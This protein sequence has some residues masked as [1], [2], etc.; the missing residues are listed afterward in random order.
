[1]KGELLFLAWIRNLRLW[2]ASQL[3][4]AILAPTAPSPSANASFAPREGRVSGKPKTLILVATIET[5]LARCHETNK[6]CTPAKTV[7][8]RGIAKKPAATSQTSRLEEKIDSLVSLMKVG[9]QTGVA[10]PQVINSAEASSKLD[11]NQ[12]KDLA[13]SSEDGS[14]WNCPDGD[15]NT[16]STTATTDSICSPGISDLSSHESEE[17][18]NHFRTF[19]L[20]YFPFVHIPPEKS[21]G[22]LRKERPFLWLC[23]MAISTK[24]TARQHD[25]GLK[26]R[27]IVAQEMVV[28]SDESID[29]LLGLLTFIGW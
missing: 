5:D 21:A 24:S 25:L 18:L 14:P 16:T 17:C 8:R 3:H 2:P 13:P 27:Q 10:L 15:Q 1:M 23:V 11:I 26:I 19:K 7:R 9:G 28:Q 29:L 12:K 20:Q 6:E 22:Q 4:T